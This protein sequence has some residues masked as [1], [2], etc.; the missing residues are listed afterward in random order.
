VSLPTITPL[1][2]PPNRRTDTGAV[3]SA[4]T[5][6]FLE[7]L[8]RLPAELN[9]FGPDLVNAA[10]ASAPVAT[11]TT[12]LL[13]SMGAKTLTVEPGKQFAGGQYVILADAAAPTTNY[14]T[15]QVI[16]YNFT[17]GVLDVTVRAVWGS[18]TKSAWFVSLSA[19][20]AAGASEYMMGL[21]ARPD[22]AAA[23]TYLGLDSPI[24]NLNAIGRTVRP[25][26]DGVAGNGTTNDRT[27]I[28]AIDTAVGAGKLTKLT[29]GN[30]RIASSLTLQSDVEFLPG[31]VLVIPDGVTVTF[32]GG[33]TAGTHQVF[34]CTGTGRVVFNPKRVW[35]G[36]AEWW[37]AKADLSADAKPSITAALTALSVVQLQMGDYL[38]A[39]QIQIPPATKLIGVG[40]NYGTEN[41]ATRILLNAAS[42]AVILIGNMT[43]NPADPY[44]GAP[45]GMSLRHVYVGRLIAHVGGDNNATGVHVG[46]CLEATLHQVRVGGPHTHSFRFA[47]AVYCKVTE[48]RAKRDV[49]CASGTDQWNGYFSDGA[50]ELSALGGNASLYLMGC[51]AEFNLG[52]GILSRCFYLG[53]GRFTDVFIDRPETVGGQYGLAIDGTGSTTDPINSANDCRIFE[54]TFDQHTVCGMLV[55]NLQRAGRVRVSGGYAGFASGRGI[56][57][58]NCHGPV[59]I[60][61]YE[62]YNYVGTDPSVGVVNSRAFKI[63]VYSS[64][65]LVHASMQGCTGGELHIHGNN[66]ARTATALIQS[67]G[68]NA[69]NILKMSATGGAG[70]ITNGLQSYNAGSGVNNFNEYHTTKISGADVVSAVTSFEAGCE[71]NSVK[72]GV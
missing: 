56:F 14:M 58:Q 72:V 20:S 27:A 11:S 8:E 21:L 1:P 35:Y 17:T 67:S 18:G 54:P 45:R 48:C 61:G 13:I 19:P 55:N 30:Y 31:A 47:G 42:G 64:E 50:Y 36:F 53:G 28:A 46:N 38:T 59:E 33:L 39:S 37:G 9:A 12:T 62:C 49:A 23:Q 5:A 10:A 44:S 32:N 7:A 65:A 41:T 52:T 34:N 40:C 22:A 70:K 69:R 16:A 3:F 51:Q 66:I 15:A 63:S 71:A 43:H 2:S 4:K 60:D 57:V 25:G 24:N 26:A 29:P 68:S 6:A